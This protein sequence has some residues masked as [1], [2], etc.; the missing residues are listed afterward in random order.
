MKAVVLYGPNDVNVGELPVLPVGEYDVRVKVAYCGICGSDFHKVAGKKNTH[1]VKY[2][3]ALG[4]EISGVVDA[5]GEKVNDFHVGD[6]VTVDPNWSC[7]KCRYCKSGKSSFCENGRGVVKGMA[8][9]VVSPVENVYH[10][11]EKLPLRSATLTEPLACCLRGM[12]ML[13]IR[14]GESVCLIGFGAIG[15]IMLQ[16]IKHS[17]AGEIAVIEY[18]EE[19][20]A[21][22]EELG[23]DVF[24]PSQDAEAIEKYA[25]EHIVD[26]VIECVGHPAVHEMAIKVAGRGATV[27][28]F[29]VA[30]SAIKTPISFYDAF[31]KELTIKTSYVNPHTTERAVRLLASGAINVE[32]TLSAV[33]TMEEAVEEFRHPVYSKRGKVLVAVNPTLEKNS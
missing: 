6:K 13:D 22:A 23:A 27:V 28:M 21:L 18:N 19:R 29:G 10:V 8:E 12:D 2:P 3:V 9:Y 7:G 31:S 20:R 14:Q 25:S 17:G 1:P 24:L 32:K 33:I 5:V 30:D 15:A 4:H 16:L 26:K 11:P